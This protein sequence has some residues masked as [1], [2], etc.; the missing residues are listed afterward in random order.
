MTTIRRLKEDGP[1]LFR[2]PTA[3]TP[4]PKNVQLT[5]LV[6]ILVALAMLLTIAMPA[7]AQSA[8]AAPATTTTSS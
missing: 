6:L 4:R 1:S 8:P 7:F 3:A 5:K 2:S